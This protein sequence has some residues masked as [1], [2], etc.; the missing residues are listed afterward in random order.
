MAM[1][2]LDSVTEA[3]P[4]SIKN[5][6]SI[7]LDQLDPRDAEKIQKTQ[8]AA[9][10]AI[11]NTDLPSAIDPSLNGKVTLGAPQP[12]V[13][14]GSAEPMEIE[15]PIYPLDPSLNLDELGV[16]QEKW[17]VSW[18]AVSEFPCLAWESIK[19]GLAK[20]EQSNNVLNG[21]IIQAEGHQKVID[22]LLEFN[23]E[24]TALGDKNDMTPRMKALVKELKENGA[25]LKI[26]ENT[27]INKDKASELKSLNSSFIDQRRSK[28]QILFTTKIQVVIQNLGSIMEA[29]KN[30]VKDN[31][32]LNSTIV[33][34]SGGR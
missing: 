8:A 32:R 28:L 12:M 2:A 10:P 15:D 21:Y 18:K 17:K 4:I 30:I 6:Q 33:G 9:L 25:D 24:L 13:V 23:A 29:L 1:N 22:L 3:K 19:A 5:D 34:H 27:K 14:D 16:D 31:T 20:E 11:Q 7:H 26:D